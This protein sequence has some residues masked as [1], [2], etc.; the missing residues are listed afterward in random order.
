VPGSSLGAAIFPPFSHFLN[1]WRRRSLAE[2]P[3][4]SLHAEISQTPVEGEARGE[5]VLSPGAGLA[6]AVV[7]G[8]GFW[9]ALLVFLF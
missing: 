6:L 4:M 3:V 7:M 9:L 2:V 8:S 5:R 1:D